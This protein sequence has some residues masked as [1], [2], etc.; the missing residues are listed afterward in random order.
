MSF[1]NHA[2]SLYVSEGYETEAQAPW[3]GM[4]QLREKLSCLAR[5]ALLRPPHLCWMNQKS[6]MCLRD[7]EMLC[8]QASASAC[9]SDQVNWGRVDL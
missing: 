7:G 1:V 4:A 3:D 6:R 9:E 8:E 5:N 2:V